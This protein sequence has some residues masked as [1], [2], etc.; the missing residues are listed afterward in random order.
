[1]TDGVIQESEGGFGKEGMPG[2][3][4]CVVIAAVHGAGV[5]AQ[6]FRRQ[7]WDPYLAES[8]PQLRRLVRLLEADLAVLDTALDEESGW[9]TCAKLREEWPG[10]RIVLLGHD[11]ARRRRLAAF[12]GADALVPREQAAVAAVPARRAA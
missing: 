9:L 12:V 2:W 5:M 4:P 1:M 6:R 8:G 3:R 11:G 10:G 7:G